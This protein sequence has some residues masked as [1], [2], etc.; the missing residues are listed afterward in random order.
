MMS[1]LILS[2]GENSQRMY[3]IQH[4]TYST[5]IIIHS[6]YV[7]RALYFHL[8]MTLREHTHYTQ[9]SLN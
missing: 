4:I 7:N 6:L 9:H 8:V 1:Y 5:I 3:H 2:V